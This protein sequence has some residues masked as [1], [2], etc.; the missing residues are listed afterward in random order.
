MMGHSVRII[1]TA[2]N[3]PNGGKFAKGDVV[4]VKAG[5]ARNYLIPQKMA[6]YATHKNFARLG[7]S[8]PHV[9]AQLES[10]LGI[11]PQSGSS[12]QT[13]TIKTTAALEKGSQE[14]HDFKAAELL[15]HYLRS[16]VV[17][18]L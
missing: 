2:E 1:A 6:V 7:L 12:L 9:E 5:F 17:S 13:T 11:I 8:D 14:E 3:L 10:L 16:K 18:R 4:T 15:K